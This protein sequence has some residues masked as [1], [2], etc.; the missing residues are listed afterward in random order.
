MKRIK[1]IEKIWLPLLLVILCLVPTFQLGRYFNRVFALIGVYAI[2]ALSLN[3]ITGYMGQTSMGH[4]GLFCVGAYVS[5]LMSVHFGTHFLVSAVI[6]ALA[7][8][9]VGFLLG[10]CTMRLSG[11]YFAITTMGFAEVVRMIALNWV[12]VTNGPL[13][14][15]NIPKPVFFG[16]TLTNTNNGF[17]WM[18]L[19]LVILSVLFCQALTNSRHGRSM[20]AVKEDELAAKLMGIN[21]NRIK[22]ETIAIAS[23]VAGFAGAYYAHMTQYIDPSVFVSDVSIT[24]MSI[25]IFGGMGSIP[26]MVLG[27][28]ILIAFPEVLR[29]L[30][31]YRFIIY[32]L[33][34]VVMMRFRP[35]GLLGGLSKK[36]YK[37]PKG[38]H[39][40]Q[41]LMGNEEESRSKEGGKINGTA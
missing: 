2:L 18:T 36:P 34:L 3:L 27:S 28:T 8:G 17:Y 19:L 37:L 7:A 6:G 33:I 35:Q 15:K 16:I 32:G 40:P 13:G 20:V 5:A 31:A 25:V 26:G 22:V 10:L 14:I 21:T 29:F 4:A 30:A 24:I 39:L 9:V 38:I 1:N 11:S 23:A 12:S 41:S